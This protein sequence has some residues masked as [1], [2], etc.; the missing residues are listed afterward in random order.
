M[1][2]NITARLHQLLR[3]G[4]AAASAAVA[5]APGAAST[6]NALRPSQLPPRCRA[7][8][9]TRLVGVQL[10]H[11]IEVSAVSV[12]GSGRVPPRAAGARCLR[13][14]SVVCWCTVF[15]THECCVLVHG[16]CNA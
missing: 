15:A 12:V 4:H 14:M 3:H 5:A 8:M 1:V 9:L 16:V 7:E 6:R 13:R 2:V 11:A 10:E